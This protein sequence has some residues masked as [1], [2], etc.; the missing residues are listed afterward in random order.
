MHIA[1][2]LIVVEEK[3][4]CIV[5]CALYTWLQQGEINASIQKTVQSVESLWL[6]MFNSVPK[7][8]INMNNSIRLFYLGG[9][10]YCGCVRHSVHG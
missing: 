10:A 4:L 7:I 1:R 3:G 8:L 9:G 6:P 2:W 5:H